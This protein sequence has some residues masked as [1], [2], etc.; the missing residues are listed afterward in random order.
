MTIITNFNQEADGSTFFEGLPEHTQEA[1]DNYLIRG[2]EPGGFLT[3]I[4]C[5]NWK[6]ALGHADTANKQ[7]FWYVA[8]W[9]TRHAPPGSTGSS[10]AFENWVKDK[11]GIRKE[12]VNQAEADFEWRTL[13][14][15]R[16]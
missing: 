6:E 9:L 11:D 8:T 15:E 13:S 5:G 14:G 1:I 2:Y 3:A 16:Q 12:Y 4:I 10:E 7:R